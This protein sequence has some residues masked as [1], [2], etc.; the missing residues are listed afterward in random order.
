MT[1]RLTQ[2]VTYD[3]ANK[4]LASRV[5]V[6]TT[7]GSGRLSLS[8]NFPAEVKA[9]SF[10]SAKV[11]EAAVLE[12]IRGISDRYSR[13]EMNLAEA[14]TE[15]KE[16]LLGKGYTPDDVSSQNEPPPGVSQEKWEE[17]KGIANIASTARLNLVFRQ[18]AAMADAIGQREVSMDP[19]I[20]ER[21][22][23]FRYITGPN[24]RPEHEALDG[25]VL[26]KDDPFWA[27]HTP[28]WDYNCNCMIE[29]CDEE[30]AK[31]YGGVAKVVASQTRPTEQTS[32][33]IDNNGRVVNVENSPSGFV[34]DAESAF[35]AQ[36]MSR[37]Q[38]VPARRSILNSIRD[39]V[40][41]NDNVRFNLIPGAAESVAAP[42][43]GSPEAV[44]EYVSKQA[45]KFAESG[46]FIADEMKIGT[47]SKEILDGLGMIEDVNLAL[48]KGTGSSGFLHVKEKHAEQIK[49]GTFAKALNE[50]VFA[51]GVR[52]SIEMNG[53][54]EYLNL[55][56][57]KT[58]ALSSFRTHVG[59]NSWNIV[60]AFYPDKHYTSSRGV[61]KK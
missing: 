61:L 23:Y 43:T 60:S 38:N 15:A 48:S 22:P 37:I 21:W 1:A 42:V 40:R 19:D 50:T 46:E 36:D 20:K 24:P 3:M 25:L 34:F 47:L 27:T 45:A 12:K 55:Y 6:P 28:P 56:N 14:R 52:V 31:Q 54:K 33:K 16:F 53:G 13:G 51:K 2:P 18:N 7:M 41:S 4:W 49:D 35:S 57:S 11:A 59:S 26:P 9:N 17:A 5:S 8:K 58:G 10:F 30:E 39:Y 32:F 29:D 44:S